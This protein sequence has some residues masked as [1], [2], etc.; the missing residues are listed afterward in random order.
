MTHPWILAGKGLINKKMLENDKSFN[1][2]DYDGALHFATNRNF[3]KSKKLLSAAMYLNTTD[4]KNFIKD[5]VKDILC[6]A[7]KYGKKIARNIFNKNIKCGNI[8]MHLEEP[9]DQNLPKG[10]VIG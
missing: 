7:P 4:N 2:I 9:P 8:F 3:L 5:L 10:V 1:L 6:V